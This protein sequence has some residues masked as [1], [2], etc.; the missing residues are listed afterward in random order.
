MMA[1]RAGVLYNF[2]DR[3]IKSGH[4]NVDFSETWRR[5]EQG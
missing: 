5:K 4:V 3:I 1:G 2:C